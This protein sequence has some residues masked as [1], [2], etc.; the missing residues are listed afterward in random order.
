MIFNAAFYICIIFCIVAV[1]RSA[2][3]LI[4]ASGAKKTLS[5]VVSVY[6]DVYEGKPIISKMKPNERNQ[7]GELTPLMNI[8]LESANAIQNHLSAMNNE[9]Q[10]CQL[11]SI[12]KSETLTHPQLLSEALSN[13]EK[14]INVLDKYEKQIGTCTGQRLPIGFGICADACALGLSGTEQELASLY[15][16]AQ[17]VTGPGPGQTRSGTGLGLEAFATCT[18][19]DKTV[20]AS[21]GCFSARRT[22]YLLGLPSIIHDQVFAWARH[23]MNCGHLSYVDR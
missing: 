6:N 9:I 19:I 17:G 13:Y 7:Y 23:R 4:E 12:F 14:A 22:K 15:P 11:D 10:E 1:Y 16:V 2:S 21:G 20:A 5:N 3:L 8:M 18:I